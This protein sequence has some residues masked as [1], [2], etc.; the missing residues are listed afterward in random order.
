MFSTEKWQWTY[1][2]RKKLERLWDADWPTQ[3]IAEELGPQVTKNM[4]IG[5]AHRM[6][7]APRRNIL[8]KKYVASKAIEKAKTLEHLRTFECLYPIEVN[9]NGEH[10]FCAQP[11]HEKFSYCLTHHKLCHVRNRRIN[12]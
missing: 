3:R 6:E 4:V 7:L 5:K 10:I 12:V 9:D 11:T 1:E 2:R 8:P